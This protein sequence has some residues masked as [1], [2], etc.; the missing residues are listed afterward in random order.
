MARG[1]GGRRSVQPLPDYTRRK[2]LSDGRWGYY[3]EP[4]TWAIRP[5]SGDDRGPCPVGAEALG[6][7]Y[8]AAV[9]RVEKVLLPLFDSWRTRGLTDMVPK[10]PRRGTLDWLFSVYRASDKFTRLGRKV[11]AL[12]DAGLA[13]V[14]DHALKDG[15]RLGDVG[16]GSI[17]ANIVDALYAKLLPMPSGRLSK[18]GRPVPLF[19][20]GL[21]VQLRRKRLPFDVAWGR[22]PIG[23][24]IEPVV[25]ERRTTVNH[26]M[27]SCRRAWNVAMRLHPK[28]VPANPFAHMGLVSHHRTVAAASYTDLV[29]A[30]AQADA[31]DLPSL[32]TA[33]MLTWEWLQREEHIFTAF[34]FAHY[35][36]KDHP[37]EVYV[38]HPKN[39]EAV[40]IPLYDAAGA[41]LFPELMARM[42]AMRRDRIGGGP[43]FVRDWRDRRT[44]VRQPWAPN[45]NVRTITRKTREILDAVGLPREITFTSFR[46]GGLTELGDADLTDAQIRAISRHKSAKVL[47][48]YVKRTEKQII[49]GTHKRRAMRPAAGAVA[50]ADDQLDLFGG[51]K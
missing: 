10:G 24:H 8:A 39:G 20:E 4:P 16:L 45:G 48:G 15:R 49:D 1:I 47:T 50:V 12:Y 34:E 17:D 23:R 37:N 25:P 36:P 51:E 32:G 13:L 31:M 40:W 27:K 46:H 2:P 11:Q 43:F 33:M 44:D 26:A 3:F 28:E 42:D 22:A 35:R 30:V 9:Q 38:V 18:D 29:A 19:R 14:A 41:A 5:K 6:T 7:D 21:P